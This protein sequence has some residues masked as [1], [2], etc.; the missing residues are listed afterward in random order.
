[1]L[2]SLKHIFNLKKVKWLSNFNESEN[3][4]NF[5]FKSQASFKYLESDKFSIDDAKGKCLSFITSTPT[6]L[7]FIIIYFNGSEKLS[8]QGFYSHKIQELI[9]PIDATHFKLCLRVVPSEN[10]N[11]NYFKFTNK[12]NIEKDYLN[13]FSFKAQFNECKPSIKQVKIIIETLFCDTEKNEITLDKYL[14]FLEAQLFIYS[15]NQYNIENIYWVVHISSDKQKYINKINIFKKKYSIKNIYINIYNHLKSYQSNE[16]SIDKRVKPNLFYPNYN[17]LFENFLKKLPR[18]F[19][20]KNYIIRIGLDDDD[21]LSNDHYLKI[22]NTV[23]K[24]ISNIKSNSETYIGFPEC[25]LVYYK[26]DG[27]ILLKKQI[28]RRIMTGNR[29]VISYN[30]IPQTSPFSLTEDFTKQSSENYII[31]SS[32]NPTFFYNRHG[33]NL[34]N[35]SKDHHTHTNISEI[36]FNN[37]QELLNYIISK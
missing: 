26:F 28:L 17:R 27:K 23:K 31:E 32:E 35:N 8:L 29:F 10:I 5:S 33:N 36:D 3:E 7:S 34:S 20:L 9:I 30:K 21:F 11:I 13:L 16:N 22:F 37:H 19:H 2:N 1:M 24:Y 14:S 6:N 25:N 15:Q 4:I 18:N 12:I